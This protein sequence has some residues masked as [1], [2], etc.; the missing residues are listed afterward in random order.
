MRRIRSLCVIATDYPTEENPVHTFIDQLVREFVDRGVNCCVVSPETITGRYLRRRT[1]QPRQEIR[2]T[3]LGN[4]YKVCSPKY[5]SLSTRL[6]AFNTGMR[7]YNSL[8]SAVFREIERLNQSFDAVYGH[9]IYPSGMCAADLS[10]R[11]GV[12]AFIA[13]GE[14]SPSLYSHVPTAILRRK[15]EKISGVV[16]VSSKNR[17]ELLEAGLVGDDKI[18]VFPNGIDGKKFFKTD[19]AAVRKKLGIDQ[20]AFVVAFVGHFIERKG[21][22]LLSS[23]LDDLEDVYSIFIGSGPREP[24]CKNVLFKGQVQHE[25]V[26]EYLNAADVFVLPTRAEGCNN[27][28]IEA[29]AC[30]LP[31]VSSNL[32]FNDDILN[33]EYSVR[34]DVTDEEQLKNA[35]VLLR[36]DEELRKKMSE[37]SLTKAA[38]MSIEKRAR[39]IIHFMETR[40]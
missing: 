9:F 14:S 17:C 6:F 25:R 26:H 1:A 19:R 15:L 12:P 18:A 10:Q 16:A 32:P 11:L 24:K 39:A 29:M 30:G 38:E 7:T 8:R 20:G 27:A 35:I 37:A 31:I 36:D 4:K 2:T 40:L 3:R 5:L 33:N 28:I 34:I 21:V 22:A 23:V 13:Y